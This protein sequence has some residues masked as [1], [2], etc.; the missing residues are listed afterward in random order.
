MIVTLLQSPQL[1]AA[2]ISL[3]FALGG[4]QI[5]LKAGSVDL[6]MPFAALAATPVV[7]PLSRRRAGARIMPVM[8]AALAMAYAVGSWPGL[9]IALVVA[10]I[11]YVYTAHISA[12][13]Y[14]TTG[15]K[16]LSEH[17]RLVTGITAA[18]QV[19]DDGRITVP[20]SGSP[21]PGPCLTIISPGHAVV[22]VSGS[23]ET[24]RT[25]PAMVRTNRFETVHRIYDLRPRHRVLEFSSV[26]TADP[27]R[28]SIKLDTHFSL[29]IRPDVLAG[30]MAPSAFENHLVRRMDDLRI[31]WEAETVVLLEQQVRAIVGGLPFVDLYGK[32]GLTGLQGAIVGG[33]RPALLAWGIQLD[34]LTLLD[35]QPAAGIA[36]ELDAAFATQ[37]R[38]PRRP[39][40]GRRDWAPAPP[41]WTRPWA[42]GTAATRSHWRCCVTW[43]RSIWPA[44]GKTSRPPS[45]SRRPGRGAPRAT[46]APCHAGCGRA[47]TGPGAR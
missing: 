1:W 31:N 12:E 11:V 20:A 42:W 29:K 46:A 40:P 15:W 45:A 39:A 24:R 36:A 22:F 35:V 8:V 27:I 18:Y 38:A 13:L 9:V 44:T 43:P 34:A 7:W 6:G 47:R 28:T 26:L 17:W 16:T 3:I 19:V 23:R 32:I 25:G 2:V 30:T 5:H 21:R 14:H 33:V 10:G 41:R 37:R 4:A